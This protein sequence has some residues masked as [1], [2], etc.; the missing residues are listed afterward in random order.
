MPRFMR[1]SSVL[2]VWGRN[3]KCRILLGYG[4]LSG[5]MPCGR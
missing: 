4:R 1:Y 5:V 3:E 2:A